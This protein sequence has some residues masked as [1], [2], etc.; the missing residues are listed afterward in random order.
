MIQQA[1]GRRDQNVHTAAQCF[2]LRLHADAAKD[3]CGTQAQ[4][5][6]VLA[7]AF[8]HLCGQLACWCEYQAAHAA[9]TRTLTRVGGQALQHGQGEGGGL[10]GP[11]LCA[12]QHVAAV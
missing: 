3:G 6:T 12:R 5:A 4:M 1:S 11:G 8:L 7:D 9:R 10:A 2:H